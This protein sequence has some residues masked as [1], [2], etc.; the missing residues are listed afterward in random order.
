MRRA[1]VTLL[2]VKVA[3]AQPFSEPPPID[4]AVQL[5]LSVADNGR[6]FH[7]G[8]IIPIKLA[9]HSRVRERYEVDQA[10]YDRSGRMNYEH[11]GVTPSDGAVDPL[12][13]Y[14]SSGTHM[15]GGLRGFAFLTGK[16]WSIRLNLNE[17]VLFTKPGE[18]KL[19]VSSKRVSVV[20]PASPFGTSRITATS[21]EI[22]LKILPR[23]P[24]WEK[25]TL[26]AAVAKSKTNSVAKL[27]D[28][29][30]SPARRAMETLR[31][32]GTPEATRE[33]VKRMRGENRALDVIC[34]FGVISS[35][36]RAV[37]REALEAALVDPNHPVDDNFLDALAFI[38]AEEDAIRRDDDSVQNE[39]KVLEKLVQALPNK[40]GKALRVSLYAALDREWIR[41]DRRLLPPG[42]TQQLTT[43]LI[44]MFDQLPQEEQAALL[45][46]RWNEVKGPALLPLLKRYAQ[47]QSDF[48]QI[49]G[50]DRF[51]VK[52]LTGKALQR[53]FE[54]DPAGARPV[55]IKEITRPRPRFGAR[56]LGMLPEKTLPEV[57]K[58]LA[59]QLGDSNDFVTSSNLASLIARYGTG[60]ILP[61]VLYK[62]DRRIGTW[63]CDVQNLLLA[64][65]IRVDPP[66]AKPRIEKA[67]AARGKSA[68]GCYRNVLSAVSATHYDPLLEEIAINALDDPDAEIATDA[69][70]VL[71][72]FGSAAAESPLWQQFERWCKR[73]KGHES[74]LMLA[75]TLS[76]YDPVNA[77]QLGMGMLEAIATGRAW[78]T[79]DAKLKQLAAA[80]DVPLVRRE[81]DRY[82]ERWNERPFRLTVYSCAPRFSAQIAQYDLDSLE[83][84]KKKLAQFAPHTEFSLSL[85]AAEDDQSCVAEVRGC[86]A[87]HEMLVTEPKTA[88]E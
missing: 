38:I 14:Y 85:P 25:R 67:I 8:E 87:G 7:I 42:A 21:N 79:D 71:G 12:A 33:L 66:S 61:Q 59:E 51:H 73:W 64:Y 22:T 13:E 31:F 35:P 9:F 50:E 15:G 83:G 56:E 5:H 32:L 40:R 1:L 82:V 16:P 52:S 54:L 2:L 20:D 46:H 58:A 62:L 60:A 48:S 49:A 81:V 69:A 18:Y 86:L 84:L 53:W 43:Q 65:L 10:Q 23:D 37:A 77:L 30:D 27:D 57:E 72:Q 28:R 26:E 88:T 3:V 75:N 29:D 55:I 78:L 70:G 19:K 36:D 41:S 39:R 68:T 76:R 45:D 34:F 74:E 4:P 44:S 63:A 6:E 17:W 11:F 80:S 24:P 47:N